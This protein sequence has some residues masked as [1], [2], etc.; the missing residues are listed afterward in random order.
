MV[1][2]DAAHYKMLFAL[3]NQS[4]SGTPAERILTA[5]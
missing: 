3:F 2:L 5:V 4:E 1:G